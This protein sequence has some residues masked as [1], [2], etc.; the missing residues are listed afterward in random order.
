MIKYVSFL[1]TIKISKV[2]YN[3]DMDKDKLK[4]LYKMKGGKLCCENCVHY[5]EKYLGY[6]YSCE[7]MKRD[8][9]S[10]K[11]FIIYKTYKDSDYIAGSIC[12]EY[13]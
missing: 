11:I 13:K 8:M 10:T 12:S 6:N 7:F 3:E 2:W 1:K 4:F 9:E 5:D